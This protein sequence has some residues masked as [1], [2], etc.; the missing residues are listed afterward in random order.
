MDVEPSRL[1]E[2]SDLLG[3]LF[4]KKNPTYKISPGS[5]IIDLQEKFLKVDLGF[6]TKEIQIESPP[7]PS[8][9]T[10]SSEM[11]I[12]GRTYYREAPQNCEDP[13]A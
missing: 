1:E 7:H 9:K 3:A 10:G 5:P 12:E 4:E 11:T 13:H 8:G 2:S 6:I